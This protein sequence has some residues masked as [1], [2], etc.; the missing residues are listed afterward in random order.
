MTE[1]TWDAVIV[2]GGPAGLSTWLHLR[3]IAPALA[4]RTL[5]LERATYPRD[6]LCGGGVTPLADMILDWLGV[7]VDVPSVPIHTVEVR[8]RDGVRHLPLRNAFRVV[9]R[10]EFDAA[11]AQA[12][13]ARGL[14]LR[15]GEAFEDFAHRDGRVRIR[16]SRREYD[17][18][19][20]IGADG[21]FSLVRQKMGL[22]DERRISRLLEVV[23]P[24][25]EGAPP[26]PSDHTALFD[27]RPM[28]EGLQGYVWRFPCLQAGCRATNAGIFDSRVRGELPRADLK[29]I[30]RNEIGVPEGLAG[31]ELLGHPLRW[32]SAGS[33]F[34]QPN[35][36][37][38]GDAAGVDALLGEGISQ[39]IEY[40]GVAANALIDAFQSGDFTFASFRRTLLRHP[41]G[42]TLL[43]RARL[44]RQMYGAEPASTE[45][46][47][48]LLA[49]W[50]SS[51]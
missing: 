11:L 48:A 13:V 21:A 27:F 50:A 33:T 36:L 32:F 46:L 49:Q 34:A 10:R 29:A 28:A 30:L 6:K 20:L 31:G 25:A 42:R 18:R 23:L 8:H 35:V 17:A 44:A 51:R 4:E 1:S 14:D 3:E 47:R 16:S 38:I 24:R 7:R 41:L 39:S 40:G 15:Q 2:G 37:L 22:R 45:A 19:V 26:E 9:Q 5:V 43:G 12:A